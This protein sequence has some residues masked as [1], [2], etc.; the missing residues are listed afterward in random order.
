MDE[1]A[2]AAL[3]G[4]LL[5][6]HL[7]AM[8]G[9]SRGVERSGFHGGALSGHLGGGES[10]GLGRSRGGL[11]SEAK[12]FRSNSLAAVL[13]VHLGGLSPGHVNTRVVL[14]SALGA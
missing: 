10:G 13:G 8:L 5:A 14:T 3:G 6:L 1:P 7:L 4:V 9:Q 11:G 12:P 2:V